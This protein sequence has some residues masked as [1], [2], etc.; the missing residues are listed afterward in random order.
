MVGAM[1]PML[2]I[3]A[4]LAR[5]TLLCA[6]G[7]GA[8]AYLILGATHAVSPGAQPVMAWDV[9]ASV[10]L[11]II[12]WLMS[13]TGPD[14]MAKRAEKTDDGRH[15]ILVLCVLAAAI[16]GWALGLEFHE[17]KQKSGAA[18]GFDIAFALVTVA[19]SWLFTH[20][21]FAAH[22]AHEY[23][24]ADEDGQRRAGLKFPGDDKDPDWWDFTHFS[25][26]IGVA[27]QTADIE[28]ESRAI[29]RTATWHGLVALVF[30]T[31]IVAVTV[32]LAAGML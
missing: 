3:R 15:F 17:A 30:N 19:L 24:G 29:R 18:Q 25:F 4:L 20:T 2:P 26:V 10:Y 11:I 27:A 6:I 32:N 1:N 12:N 7:A 22:Y 31:V 28:I 8:L 5:P 9:A 16:S 23:Y 14:V 21:V 13:R